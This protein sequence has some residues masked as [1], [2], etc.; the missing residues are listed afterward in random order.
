M[1]TATKSPIAVIAYAMV[2]QW[3]LRVR[4]TGNATPTI[5]REEDA[6]TAVT[7]AT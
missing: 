6:M 5:A 2:L 4:M 1:R 3:T 7:L